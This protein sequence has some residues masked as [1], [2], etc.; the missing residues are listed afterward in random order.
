[1]IAKIIAYGRDRDEALGRLRR[2]MARDHR[3]HRRRRDQQELRA[4]PA[5]PARGDRR[6]RGHRLDRPGPR[7]GQARRAAG[8]PPSRWPSPRSRPTRTRRRSPGSGCSSTAHGGRP[9]VQHDT[10]RPVELKLRGVGYRVR[11]GR[12]GAAPVPRRDRGGRRQR[13]TR[14]TSRSS[15]STRTAA[16]SSSTASVSGW[17]P[18]RT[19]RSTWSRWTAWRTGSA[20]TRA[21]WSARPRPPWWSPPRC[22]VGDEV[23][24]GAPVLVLESHEDGDGAARAVPRPAAR[25]PGLGGQPGRGRRAAAA[26]GAARRRR[27]ATPAGT[28]A[29]QAGAGR[30]DRPARRARRRVR[31]RAGRSA[32]CATCAGC[33]S[34]STLTRTTSAGVLD[35]YL[36]ARAELGH[37]TTG[38]WRARSS[39]SR[40]SPTCP[41]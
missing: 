6:E 37:G 30:R 29:G 38:R 13:R 39:C 10:G 20:A 18:A 16:R 2:A 21:A 34:A 27:R 32:A 5:G 3:D 40:C 19:G 31:G 23:E 36:A 28:P 11:V 41:S 35:G 7:R 15:A 9:Q 8:T 14:P 26:A 4:R 33:C 12:V 25:V 17:S 1:M 24:A 22:A